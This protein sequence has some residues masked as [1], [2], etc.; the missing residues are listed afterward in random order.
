[1]TDQIRRDPVV[2]WTAAGGLFALALL[3]AAFG[4]VTSPRWQQAVLS[5][6]W[7]LPLAWRRRWPVV[8]LAVVMGAGG[9]MSLV[10]SEGGLISFVLAA[11]LAAFTVGRHVGDQKAWWGPTLSVGYWWGYYAAV[12]GSLSDYEFTALIYGGAWA[13]GYILRRRDA[14]IE[15]LTGVAEGLRTEA[16]E[17]E[18][19]AVERERTRIARE[20]HDVVSHSI[21]AVVI[22]T[23]AIRRRLSAGEHQDEIDDL[24]AVETAARQAMAEMR[25]LVGMLRADGEGPVLA[26]QPGLDQLGALLVDMERSGVHVALEIQGD[27]V[28]LPPGVDLAAYRI[29]QEGLT[30]VMR[31]AP[32]AP[33]T[34]RLE[35]RG[36][37][38]RLCIENPRRDSPGTAPASGRQGLIGMRERVVLYGGT[39]Q[40]GASAT[41]DFTVEAS[42]PLRPDA[43]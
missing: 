32:G 9:A 39:F 26:P 21:S 25:R 37:V 1:M 23:Q 20:L 19:E 3:E 7:T 43:S 31:H 6:V 28:G 29:I 27:P 42:L 11:V 15:H 22:Q 36:D 30:N 2:D 10:N 18:R 13:V 4:P 24:G 14:R 17:R 41:G 12:G 8:V 38:L 40:A 33:A 35:Y 34:V 16:A 5:A